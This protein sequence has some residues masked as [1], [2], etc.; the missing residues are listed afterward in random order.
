MDPIAG[1][2]ER[3]SRRDRARARR[4]KLG[5]G[6]C[7]QKSVGQQ[8]IEKAL[9]KER[10]EKGQAGLAGAGRGTVIPSKKEKAQ[11]PYRKQKHKGQHRASAQ[12]VASAYLARRQDP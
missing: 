1:K 8:A 4:T 7:K 2:K 10:K 11:R 9:H 3:R 6:E 5:P 12:R